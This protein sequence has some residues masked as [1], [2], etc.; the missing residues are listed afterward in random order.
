MAMQ[1]PATRGPSLE[2]EEEAFKFA[3][4]VSASLQSALNEL[5][6]SEAP[7]PVPA[8]PPRWA[9]I[10]DE[11]E[12]PEFMKNLAL[13]KE[14]EETSSTQV[15]QW[16]A[17]RGPSLDEFA[18][19]ALQVAQG[20]LLDEFVGAPMFS[21]HDF[22]ALPVQGNKVPETLPNDFVTAPM[23][24]NLEPH[25]AP[26]VVPAEWNECR[27][28]EMFAPPWAAMDEFL[29]AKPAFIHKDSLASDASTAVSADEDH[30]L[31]SPPSGLS[32]DEGDAEKDTSATLKISLTDTLGL[33][34]IGSAA[35]EIGECKP[36]AFLW[37]DPQQPG[38]Q[39]GREC[40][41]CHLCPPGE[42]K[43]RK[44][45]KLFMRK[46]A[47]NLWY[48]QQ[49]SMGFQPQYESQYE[50]QYE[51]Q[52]QQNQVGAGFGMW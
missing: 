4:E 34:S 17:T 24:S 5:P 13:V 42:V 35:H 38:C 21:N 20:P 25:S 49:F 37:K 52:Y 46:V 26:P 2:E 3:S 16:P 41:F 27:V 39:N 1:W 12:L 51:P 36:C 32:D 22:L 33:W 29:K 31:T 40:V 44:K 11:E 10:E 15:F 14:R 18:A 23:F 7:C 30:A 43:R 8:A 47:K 45:Q 48:D 9:S 50:P 6:V 28:S 19:G